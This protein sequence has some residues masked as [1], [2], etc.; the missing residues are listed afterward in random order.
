MLGANDISCE[1]W[2]IYGLPYRKIYAAH[3]LDI[4]D[5]K[6]L[7]TSANLLNKYNGYNVEGRR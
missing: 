7:P 2:K 4:L 1:F 6:A 3:L 5:N